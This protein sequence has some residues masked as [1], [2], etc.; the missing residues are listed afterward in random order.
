[1]PHGSLSTNSINSVTLHQHSEQ[2]QL[3]IRKPEYTQAKSLAQ[4]LQLMRDRTRNEP[5]FRVYY[6]LNPQASPAAREAWPC[7]R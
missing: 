4:F 6:L 2:V 5:A 3:D 7:A 1:M